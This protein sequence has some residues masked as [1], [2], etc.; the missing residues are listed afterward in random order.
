MQRS[1]QLDVHHYDGMLGNEMT[2]IREFLSNKVSS[3]IKLDTVNNFVADILQFNLP[4]KDNACNNY[5]RAIVSQWGTARNYDPTNNITAEDM[6]Y[7][8]ALEFNNMKK[9]FCSDDDFV[10][11]TLLQDFC[12]ELFIQLSDVQTGGCPQG[13]AT[14]LW[15]IVYGYFEYFNCTVL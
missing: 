14:R 8:C 3:N 1:E 5:L 13:R 4:E 12:R 9:L 11:N 15:Q 6:I 7:I 10:H 2:I